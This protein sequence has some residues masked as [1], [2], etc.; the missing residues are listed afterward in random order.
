[1]E[2]Q[3]RSS[4]R[5]CSEAGCGVRER[6]PGGWPADGTG[7]KQQAFWCAALTKRLLRRRL[8]EGSE[9]LAL[10]CSIQPLSVIKKITSA[11]KP[12]SCLW[13][14][15]GVSWATLVNA[16][17]N[18]CSSSGSPFVLPGSWYLHAGLLWFFLKQERAS[19][20]IFP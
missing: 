18:C 7:A 3:P 14:S 19:L 4:L 10:V 16:I 1:M 11:Y 8:Q 9:N 17:R 5:G 20:H 12:P 2:H 15:S 13:W 6:V